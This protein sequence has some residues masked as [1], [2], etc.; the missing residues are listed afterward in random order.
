MPKSPD[1]NAAY[2]SNTLKILK[3][4]KD[5]FKSTVIFLALKINI[6]TWIIRN[7]HKFK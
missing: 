6:S 7:I 5:F 4:T 3:V 2:V 1:L